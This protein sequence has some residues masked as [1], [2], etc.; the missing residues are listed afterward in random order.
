VRIVIITG[1]ASGDMYGSLLASEIHRLSK[2]AHLAGVGG[3]AM[4]EA[5]VDI[6]LGSGGISVV[7]I[8]EAAV[9]LGRLRKAMNRIKSEIA[10]TRP[11]LV[12]LIDYPGMNLRL[13][14]FAKRLGLRVMYYVSPQVWAWGRNR[15]RTVRECVDKMV[16]ILPFEAEI[17]RR[18][19]VDVTYVGHPLI[20]VVK[21]GLDRGSF[22]ARYGL[23]PGRRRIALLSGSRRQEIKQHLRPLLG[24]SAILSRKLPD[25][26]F[27]TVTLPPLERRVKDEIGKSGQ[28]VRVITDLRYEAIAYSDLA[29]MCSGT[30]TLE[31]ALLG[32]PMIVM[33]RLAPLSWALG[34]MIVRVPYIS[35]VNLV[36]REEI[37]PEFIQGAAKA[38]PL[39]A[40]ALRILEDG[41]RRRYMIERLHDVKS[42]LGQ[43]DATRKAAE[44]AL[45]LARQ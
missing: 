20:D 38:E 41:P 22:L 19:G 43:G 26:D 6:F 31:G 17:Y 37:V 30:V 2:D 32:T 5:G 40:E 3:Q 27:V 4:R 44:I 12:V 29:I 28:A 15:I 8:W 21:T 23:D 16:V 18:E 7:G 24:A 25:L 13:A 33:Y 35:L 36:G 45:S 39:A 11:D 10:S 42:Q 34:R 14:R 1:E 9:R